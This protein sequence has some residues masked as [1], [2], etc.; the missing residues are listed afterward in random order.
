MVSKIKTPFPEL[1]DLRKAFQFDDDSGRVWLEE[2]RMLL[3]HAASLGA[4]RNELIESL[5]WERAKGVLMRMGYQSG[6][7]D[8]QLARKLRPDASDYE[9]F[10]V[11]PQL[12]TLEGIVQV[13]P[14]K[15]ELNIDKGE[16]YGEFYWNYSFEAEQHLECYGIHPEPVCWNQIGYACGYTSEL[17]GTPVIY[18]EMECAGCGHERCRIIG[19]PAEEWDNADEMTAYFSQGSV[20]ETIFTLKDEVQHLRNAIKKDVVRSDII[21][22]SQVIHE[23]LKV[24]GKASQTNV[25]V[26]ML[27]ETGVGKDTFARLL[28]NINGPNE[29]PFVQVNCAALPADLVEAELF[30]VEKGAYT[31][32]EKSRPGR[33]ERAHGGT[34]FLDEIGEM[35]LDIQAKL[36]RIL[37]TGEF[38]RV[39][40]TRTR[41]VKVRLITATNQ[42]LEE[43]VSK[44]LFRADLYYRINVFPIVIPPLRERKDDIVGLIN[45]FI[46]MFNAE[47]GKHVLGVED[48]VLNTFNQYN[49]PGNIRE[50]ENIIE[51][52]VILTDSGEYINQAY[53]NLDSSLSNASDETYTSKGIM[54]IDSLINSMENDELT[55]EELEQKI[56]DSALKKTGGNV[57]AAS[58]LLN[59][60]PAK[61]RYRI[62]KE[63]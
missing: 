42:P 6:K 2:Q 26:L 46:G 21:C 28:H 37:Q 17:M 3:F 54:P 43:L 5:G 23:T 38:E 7:Q 40:E 16:H 10:A 48:E 24:L 41:K 53:I 34:L 31:G 63:K 33:F 11:G 49:W 45:K 14:I 27:G 13:V 32:A 39:G 29:K 12:H 36:L 59:I 25:T 62:Q 57:T 4:L 19:K 51:R 15:L 8:A 44:G 1:D 60:T 47:Y 56:L 52:G 35:S 55:L 20:A 9:L 50:L 58:R 61:Y 30:G 18:Q 22:D